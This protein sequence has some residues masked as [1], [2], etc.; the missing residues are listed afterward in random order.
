M[1]MLVFH[2]PRRKRGCAATGGGGYSSSVFVS[3]VELSIHLQP[4]G[5]PPPV[6]RLAFSLPSRHCC[7]A[8][9][10][11]NRP[12]ITRGK[13]A[14][15]AAPDSFLV[16]LPQAPSSG[17]TTRMET[18]NFGTWKMSCLARQPTYP[19]GVDLPLLGGRGRFLAFVCPTRAPHGRC[20]LP[21]AFAMGLPCRIPICRLPQCI[22][23]VKRYR[24]IGS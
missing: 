22:L 12:G 10:L 17:V 15:L 11:S 9:V 19:P 13:R 1:T 2:T 7:R 5:F 21:P 16:P 18:T 3:S 24:S 4:N 14:R 8:P 6:A 23:F 20:Q